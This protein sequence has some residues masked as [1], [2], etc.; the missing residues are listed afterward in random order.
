MKHKVI[1][2][3]IGL[4]LLEGWALYLGFDGILLNIVL[5]LIAGLGGYKLKG[6]KENG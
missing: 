4:V 3:I 5:I 6:G 1:T 2:A